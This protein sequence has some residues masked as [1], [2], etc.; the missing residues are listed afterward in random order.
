MGVRDE[1]TQRERDHVT[2]SNVEASGTWVPMG[3]SQ[4]WLLVGRGRR[5]CPTK[6]CTILIEGL[7]GRGEVPPGIPFPPPSPHKEEA[8]TCST[9]FSWRWRLCGGA[10]GWEEMGHPPWPLMWGGEFLVRGTWLL[11]SDFL[12]LWVSKA[13]GLLSPPRWGSGGWSRGGGHR[14]FTFSTKQ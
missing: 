7:Q 14:R 12:V 10:P 2:K 11:L 5:D 4:E 13:T 8:P 6:V 3:Y 1:G 9:N